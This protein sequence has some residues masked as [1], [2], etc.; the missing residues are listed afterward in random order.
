[1]RANNAWH[2][3]DA[4]GGLSMTAEE[5]VDPN[6]NTL[7]VGDEVKLI[8]DRINEDGSLHALPYKVV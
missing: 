6:G 4:T 8:V 2:Y 3:I 1:M 7:N 5:R